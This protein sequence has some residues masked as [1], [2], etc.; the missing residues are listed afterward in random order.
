MKRDYKFW[1]AA[2]MG[3]LVSDKSYP[4]QLS[5]AQIKARLSDLTE[6]WEFELEAV[7]DKTVSRMKS[8]K[9][10]VCDG[11]DWQVANYQELLDKWRADLEAMH[12][13]RGLIAK[14]EAK[15]ASTDSPHEADSLRAKAAE[16]RERVL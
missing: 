8:D 1:S 13:R 4:V 2:I 7:I 10:V 16:L 5:K 11:F 9:R 12:R 3:L 6:L 15:A 14:L